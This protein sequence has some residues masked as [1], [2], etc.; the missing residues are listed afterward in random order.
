[1]N[2]EEQMSVDLLDNE[3]DQTVNIEPAAGI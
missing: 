1:M 2:T 3:D